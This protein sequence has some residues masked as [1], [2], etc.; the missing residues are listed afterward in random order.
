M[1]RLSTYQRVSPSLVQS[2]LIL[3]SNINPNTTSSGT[4]TSATTRSIS[5]CLLL[6]T[7]C[8]YITMAVCYRLFG[9]GLSKRGPRLL[10][11]W[12]APKSYCPE[13]KEGAFAKL[14]RDRSLRFVCPSAWNNPAPTGWIFLKFHIPVFFKS[15]SRKF[16]FH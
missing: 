6:C 12:P 7:T 5:D 14:R 1:P 16:K 9:A 11:M 10:P 4:E 13:Q 8:Q 15:L 3:F 2:P